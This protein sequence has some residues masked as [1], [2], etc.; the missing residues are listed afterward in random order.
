MLE[1]MPAGQIDAAALAADNYFLSLLAAGAKQGIL[2]DADLARLQSESFALPHSLT[3][4]S[5][6]CAA[7]RS[8]KYKIYVCISAIRA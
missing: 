8:R 4:P 7:D 6:H 1:L 5:A 2:T 3:P